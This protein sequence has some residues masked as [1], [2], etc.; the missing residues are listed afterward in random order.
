MIDQTEGAW[1]PTL[2]IQLVLGI[3][4]AMLVLGG[5]IF[6]IYRFL[7]LRKGNIIEI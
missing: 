7:L 5:L 3:T 6:G 2:I 1:T 4:Q